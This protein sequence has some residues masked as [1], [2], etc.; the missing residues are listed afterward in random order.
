MIIWPQSQIL[1]SNLTLL[2]VNNTDISETNGFV[3]E[4]FGNYEKDVV[5][6]YSQ[7]KAMQI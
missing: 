6:L 7:R 1:V 2:L 3:S 5:L 4:G